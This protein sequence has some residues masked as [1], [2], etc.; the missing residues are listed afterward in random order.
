MGDLYGR[1]NVCFAYRSDNCSASSDTAFSCDIGY[2]SAEP[3]RPKDVR[4][5]DWFAMTGS[6]WLIGGMGECCGVMLGGP[7][8]VGYDMLYCMLKFEAGTFSGGGP[9]VKKAGVPY[10]DGEFAVVADMGYW[11]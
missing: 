1:F 7:M 11:R 8:G 2:R 5:G 6:G 4:G 3:S 10:S 9:E